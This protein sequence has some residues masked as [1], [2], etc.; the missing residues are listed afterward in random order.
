M[1]RVWIHWLYL[2]VSPKLN[3]PLYFRLIKNMLP[4]FRKLEKMASKI[5]KK[6]W[7]RFQFSK[8]LLRKAVAYCVNSCKLVERVSF[9]GESRIESIVCYRK[10][11]FWFQVWK[12]VGGLMFERRWLDCCLQAAKLVRR[13]KWRWKIANLIK[14]PLLFMCYVNLFV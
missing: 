9:H 7:D 10:E 3:F 14:N 1:W 8:D 2:L 6:N 12:C 5:W 11:R 4:I 13:I